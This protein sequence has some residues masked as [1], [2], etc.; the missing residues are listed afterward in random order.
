MKQHRISIRPTLAGIL[1]AS[2]FAFSAPAAA[3]NWGGMGYGH[4]ACPGYVPGHG[5]GPHGYGGHSCPH[6]HGKPYHRAA[7]APGLSL[8]V[9]V[10]AL[11]HAALD[12]L[13]LNYGIRVVKV[14]PGS[15]AEAAGITAEDI[16]LEFD[17]KPVYSGDRLRWLVRKGE[18]GK[19]VEIKLQR[20]DKVMSL[21][22]MPAAP[23]A[24]P[25]CEER[26]VPSSST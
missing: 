23:P 16:I 8:G 26:P 17:G 19:Q 6:G 21:T 2:L 20:D 4:P 18:E 13:G 5:M 11:P 3:H 22:A 9:M 10:T 1:L 15:A 7:M 24:K 12:E 14:K 25:K